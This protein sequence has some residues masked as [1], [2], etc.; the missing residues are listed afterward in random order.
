MLINNILPNNCIIE[1]NQ[2]KKNNKI[3][4]LTSRIEMIHHISSKISKLKIKQINQLL[5][6]QKMFKK[7]CNNKIKYSKE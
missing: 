1:K 7:L 3:N 2:F 5:V 4:Q 6:N